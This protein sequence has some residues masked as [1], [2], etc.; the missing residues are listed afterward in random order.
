M[1]PRNHE[2]TKPNCTYLLRA[3]VF[4][5]LRF[6]RHDSLL[7]FFW[8]AAPYSARATPLASDTTAA[9]IIAV[10]SSSAAP[11]I[12]YLR[13]DFLTDAGS[14]CIKFSVIR[15]SEFGIWNSASQFR[16]QNS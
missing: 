2:D 14:E 12:M 8:N 5:W 7:V 10:N 6:E 1:Q 11:I 13:T 4:S 15:N 16:I 3:F 9:T